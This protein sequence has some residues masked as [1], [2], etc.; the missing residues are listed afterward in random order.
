[1]EIDARTYHNPSKAPELVSQAIE[2]AG[3]QREV[4]ARIG[5]TPRYLQ[6]LSRGEREMSYPVQVLLEQITAGS[7]PGQF[8]EA[9]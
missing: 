5:V 8:E 6:L 1:M 9:E 7:H 2:V 4:A 3:T